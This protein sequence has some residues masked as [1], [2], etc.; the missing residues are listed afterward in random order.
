M[1]QNKQYINFNTEAKKATMM[2]LIGLTSHLHIFIG[3]LNRVWSSSN[4]TTRIDE[5][6]EKDFKSKTSSSPPPNSISSSHASSFF[7]LNI[8][9]L[10]PHTALS[11]SFWIS[12]SK[13]GF[14]HNVQ[15][16]SSLLHILIH[17]CF[18]GASKKIPISMISSCR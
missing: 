6:N 11:S 14:K 18:I 1:C 13:P 9:Q 7:S 4:T 15:S 2:M 17:Y 12:K 5:S 8:Y 3:E 16:H 10:N